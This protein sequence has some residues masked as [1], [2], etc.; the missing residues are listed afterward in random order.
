MGKDTPYYPV[1]LKSI[2]DNMNVSNR[3][4]L[5]GLIDKASQ[6]TEEQ[7]KAQDE[8]RQADLAFLASQTAAL[9][10]QAEESRMRAHKLHEEALAVPQETDIA[11]M[12][13]ITTNLQ[14]G[15]EE[16]KEFERRYRIAEGM[17]K[18]REVELKER[19]ALSSRESTDRPSQ[20]FPLN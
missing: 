1:M 5:M 13:A 9:E 16:D 6:P 8:Q 7:Q 11:R 15:T 18:E 4:E 20:P 3:E 17:L 19:T 14:V 10:A 12:K 2:V